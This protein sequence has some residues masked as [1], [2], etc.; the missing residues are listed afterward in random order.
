MGI[1]GEVEVSGP[2]KR[3]RHYAI[4]L[5]GPCVR[6]GPDRSRR[7]RGRAA[8]GPIIT[9]YIASLYYG[10][11][12]EV[13]FAKSLAVRAFWV[14]REVGFGTFSTFPYKIG[15][16]AGSLWTLNPQTQNFRATE[17]GGYIRRG[18]QKS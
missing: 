11:V 12:R 4:A 9:T 16:R 8:T 5:E 13:I 14:A 10:E 6:F 18:K 1:D 7:Q 17:P 3:A 2:Y 15:R